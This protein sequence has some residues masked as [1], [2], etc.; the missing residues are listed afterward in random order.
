MIV[1]T[2]QSIRPKTALLVSVR[3]A[4]EAK[5]ARL[6][7]AGLIDCKEPE[8]GPLGR[9]RPETWA[10]I[11]TKVHGKVPLSAALGEWHEWAGMEDGAIQAIL[12]NLAGFQYAKLGPAGSTDEAQAFFKTFQRL[13]RLAPSGLKWICVVYTDQDRA[14]SLDRHE[15]LAFAAE[16]NC[17]GLLMDTFDK[18]ARQP[19]GKS[20]FSFCRAVHHQQLPLALAGGLTVEK[21]KSLQ[22]IKPGWFAVRGAACRG[23]GR[24]SSVSFRRVRRLVR[25]IT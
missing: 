21:I 5:T 12:K 16:S 22:E 8:R 19:W 15:L 18:T 14:K 3:S 13:K 1:N 10:A 7:G 23:G 4:H 17:D 24:M 2:Q 11:Q 25:A 20:F 6:A 9:C